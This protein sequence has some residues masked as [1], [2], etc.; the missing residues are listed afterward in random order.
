MH[1]N[2]ARALERIRE[3]TRGT[4]FENR[5]YLVGGALRDRALGLSPRDE[6]DLV[7]EG[8][9]ISLA[10]HL[11][12][13]GISS[14]APVIYPR[15]RTAKLQIE[16][17]DVELASARAE[18]YDPAH[19]K[20]AVRPA[21]LLDDVLR[22]DFTVNTLIENLHT[23]EELDLTGRA[24]ADLHARILRT[25]CD[26]IVTFRDDPL[27]MLRAV[28][29]AV[30]L[31]FEIEPT[32]WSAILS[33]ANRLDLLGP[34]PPVVSAERIRDEFSK[35]LLSPD[36][37]RGMELLRSGRLLAQFAPELLEMVGVTQNDWH[38]HDV[39]NHTLA[40]LRAVPADS[41]LELR[42]GVLLHDVGKPR[43]RTEDAKGVHFYEHQFVGDE[44]A[45]TLLHRLKYANHQIA[46]VCALVRLHMRF[47]EARPDWS[48]AAIRRLIRD[49]SPHIE[50][51]YQLSACDMAA[52]SPDA[53]KTDL[54]ALRRRIDEVEAASHA[55]RIRSPLD[56]R[57]IMRVLGI[58]EGP[59]I[60]EAKEY[61]VNEVVEGRLSME[62][63]SLATQLLLRWAGR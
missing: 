44:I 28:R 18:S 54:G 22:R 46:T 31:S 25:P 35:T 60:R 47:G 61:L 30:R 16:G 15:F 19:R 3:A 39:W 63:K 20:P 51:L 32:T 57:E 10:R 7:V 40:A 33:E 14:H 55:S 8:D 23:G 36:P 27:R 21:T 45:H 43:T 1:S 6:V 52:M 50:P 62:D 17:C 11:H 53:P 24:R 5:V 26:P 34:N 13:A 12:E 42:L 49:T 59:T 9:A 58:P 41:P 38:C 2:D 37:A 29:F 56:G 4:G 48:D